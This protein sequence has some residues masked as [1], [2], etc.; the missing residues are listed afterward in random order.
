M[1]LFQPSNITPSTFAGLGGGTVAVADNVN[2]TW[3]VNG[4][5]P[6]TGFKIDIYFGAV[7]VG[8]T[9]GVIAISNFYP[10]DN[11]GNPN[12][13][14]YA[15]A[16]TTWESWGL[17]DGKQYTMQITQY[18]TV[19]TAN[20][21]SISQYSQ[22]VFITR[23]IPTLNFSR[24]LSTLN[25]VDYYTVTGTITMPDIEPAYIVI[26]TNNS[27]TN[28]IPVT[29][30]IYNYNL[31]ENDIIAISRADGVA[32]IRQNG[33]WS[34]VTASVDSAAGY[35]ITHLVS[36]VGYFPVA[37]S[38]ISSIAAIYTQAQ[39]DALNWVKWE[40]TK[41]DPVTRERSNA[42]FNTGNIFTSDLSI[43]LPAL[44][45]NNTYS[46]KCTIETQ[47]GIQAETGTT[48]LV[49]YPDQDLDLDVTTSCELS[50]GSV[51][52]ALNSWADNLS[53]LSFYQNNVG[54]S[55]LT[56]LNKFNLEDITQFKVFSAKNF[57]QYSIDIFGW[58]SN[59]NIIGNTALNG[60]T[61]AF[62]SCY[63]YVTEQDTNDPNIYHVV[64]SWRFGNN[65]STGSVSNNNAPNFLTNFTKYRL[66]QQTS[67]MGKSGTLQ[68]L[69]SNVVNSRYQDTA[70]Q[71]ENLYA[72]SQCKNP[73]FLKDT[74][75]NLYMV[76]ISGA[77]T[78]SVNT[79]S[80]YQEVTVSIPWE[81]I[82][83]TE[84]ISIIQTPNDQGWIENNAMLPL[85]RFTVDPETGMLQV[86]YPSNYSG[87]TFSI[88]RNILV[89][90]TQENV[91]LP[92]ISID[93][94]S[95]ILNNQNGGGS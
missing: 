24:T 17:E 44:V 36:Y 92:N 53:A 73:M 57:S 59:S 58:D 77:I 48:L 93:G 1:P 15:P 91:P 81:E 4:N 51:L 12:Y 50:D 66:K 83:D 85:V 70:L 6:M 33:E 37:T 79:K 8:G 30:N 67:R 74:K 47:N 90:T 54:A 39:G 35:N 34:A 60:V 32:Y 94:N 46:I 56:L 86:I 9:N 10:T 89:A 45:E 68:A 71:M 22:S 28:V 27:G 62:K 14:T 84:N 2:I 55:I 72:I 23:T 16:D 95:V 13:Y 80:A 61:T 31:T 76:N 43:D 11:K 69:L 63:L 65:L 29:L 26:P 40:I 49:Y 20:D 18:W 78:Q 82:G 41:Y 5:V 3:Q 21:N 42:V 88:D 38:L 25:S 75:G 87:T 64:A 7:F 19:S 52:Y